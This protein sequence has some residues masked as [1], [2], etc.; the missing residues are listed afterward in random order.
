MNTVTL[1]RVLQ[2]CHECIQECY[3]KFNYGDKLERLMFTNQSVGD[4]RKKEN[5]VQDLRYQLLALGKR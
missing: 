1:N 2:I 4:L 3:T 5:K